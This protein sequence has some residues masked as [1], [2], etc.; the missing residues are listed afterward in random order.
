MMT[1]R[2][3]LYFSK[4]LSELYYSVVALERARKRAELKLSEGR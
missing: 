4:P 1:R 2:A 3:D